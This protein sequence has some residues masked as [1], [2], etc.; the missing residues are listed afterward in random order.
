[1]LVSRTNLFAHF[2]VFFQVNRSLECALGSVGKHWWRFRDDRA[3]N[4]KVGKIKFGFG[5]RGVH[6]P[7]WIYT[8]KSTRVVLTKMWVV[9][10]AEHGP[11]Q[12]SANQHGPCS[13]QKPTFDS[14]SYVSYYRLRVIFTHTHNIPEHIWRGDFEGYCKGL[15][16]NHLEILILVFVSCNCTFF[17][18]ISCLICS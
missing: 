8:A 16:I 3:K 15:I 13:T 17:H 2:H 1:M 6:G 10:H 12:F 9:D 4:E 14:Y 18:L 11:C 5:V 7:C